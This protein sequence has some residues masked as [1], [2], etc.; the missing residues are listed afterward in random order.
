MAKRTLHEI[1]IGVIMGL[2]LVWLITYKFGDNARL[3][4]YLSFALTISSLLLSA[5]AIALTV[6]AN[7][8]FSGSIG[9][10]LDQHQ[11]ATTAASATADAKL[12][13]SLS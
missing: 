3:T 7:S 13:A 11:N 8:E 1:Y 4:D 2:F 10:G 9:S 12:A 6:L 5:V